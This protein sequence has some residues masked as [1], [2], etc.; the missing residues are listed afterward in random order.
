[1]AKEGVQLK[2]K[3]G[4]QGDGTLIEGVW[5]KRGN[6]NDSPTGLF[7]QRG[8]IA[9][10]VGRKGDQKWEGRESPHTSGSSDR[11]IVKLGR[12]RGSKA[13]SLLR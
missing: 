2:W 8:H 7:S 9:L 13:G 12:T 1:L 6:D 11:N 5:R 4:V 3:K 10:I